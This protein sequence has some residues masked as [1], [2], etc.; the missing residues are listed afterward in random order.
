MSN[1]LSFD[2]FAS[3]QQ[4]GAHQAGLPRVVL[5]GQ[6]DVLLFEAWFRHFLDVVEFVEASNVLVG[7]GCESVPKAVEHSRMRDQVPAVGIVDRDTLFRAK[8]WKELYTCESE[9]FAAIQTPDVVTASLWE[10]EAYLLRPDLLGEWVEV[11]RDQLP[12]PPEVC[13]E[14]ISLSLEEAEALLDAMPTLA[15]LHMRGVSCP[16]NWGLNHPAESLARECRAH[17]YN[18]IAEQEADAVVEVVRGL[19]E[20]IKALAPTDDAERFLYFLRYVDTKRLLARLSWRLRLLGQNAHL[21]LS[22]LMSKE[23]YCPTELKSIVCEYANRWT[24]QGGNGDEL[25]RY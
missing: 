22:S 23:G 12:A 10:V 11:R 14:A 3:E 17:F 2:A 8:R 21:A 25:L 15:G 24:S 5:E 16:I 18:M 9:V 1:V 6:S 4:I 13:A 20:E 7:G 19:V